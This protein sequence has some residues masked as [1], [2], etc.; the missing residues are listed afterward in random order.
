MAMSKPEELQEDSD[1]IVGRLSPVSGTSESMCSTVESLPESSSTIS[2]AKKPRRGRSVRRQ[3]SSPTSAPDSTSNEEALTPYWTESS[4]ERLRALQS[5][6]PTGSADSLSDSLKQSQKPTALASWFSI[7]E[8]IHPTSSLSGTSSPLSLSSP[9]VFTA[10]EST[11]KRVRKVRVYPK[12]DRQKLLRFFGASRFYFNK[13][14]EFLRQPGTLASRYAIQK[15]LLK[16]PPEWAADV[17]YKIRQMAIDDACLAVKAAKKKY[18][19]TGR[20]HRVGFR[21]KRDRNDSFYVPKDAVR[22]DGVFPNSFSGWHVTEKVGVPESD[23]RMIHERGK[24]WL[25]VPV[26]KKI[27]K[28]DTQRLARISLDPGVRTFLTGYTDSGYLHFGEND[29]QLVFKELLRMDRM[30]SA[31]QRRY[32]KAIDAVR[33]RVANLV[34]E[35]H[36]RIV[37]WLCKTFDTVVIPPFSA[38]PKMLSRLRSKTCRSLLTWAHA[39]FLRRLRDK[40]EELSVNLVIQSE[41]YTSKTCSA[42][43]RIRNIGS[44]R[45]WKCPGCC[46]TWDRD[47]NAARGILLR[48]LVDQPSRFGNETGV[49]SN[50]S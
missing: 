25:C 20:I 37:S 26:N 5:I 13:T 34:I 8:K 2:G 18:V 21:S 16:D 42:C 27:Q 11:V 49:T 47:E 29:F 23:C 46:R 48:A 39:R 7:R 31:G 24:F 43:G 44:A 9:V 50:Q 12:A 19:C 33:F 30:I 28:P 10:L 6:M 40:C 41:A 15:D 1:C 45:R 22:D 3:R 35:M 14:V 38:S 32:R 4:D 17:P 36:S